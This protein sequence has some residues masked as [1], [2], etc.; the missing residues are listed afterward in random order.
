L[1]SLGRF[2]YSVT[3]GSYHQYTFS[4]GE[5]T[6]LTAP[7]PSLTF[8]E[9]TNMRGKGESE[10]SGHDRWVLIDGHSLAYRAFYALP[11]DLATTSGQLTNAVY[12]FTSMLIKVMEEFKPHAVIVAFDKGKPEFRT[13]R[14][15]EYKAHRKPMPDELRDQMD[16]IH[17]VLDSLGIP[18]L[19]E[20]GFEADDV[21]A[22]L[23]DIL[24]QDAEIYIVTSDRD[25]MQLVD[26]RVK[27]IANRKGISDIAVF[28]ARG[29]K[30][31]FGV[32]PGQIVDYLAL[33]G[34]TSDNI[35]GV[36]GIGEKTAAAL[37]GEYGSL[38]DVY[39]HIREIKAGRARKALEDNRDSALMSRELATM[40]HDVPIEVKG[41][42]NWDLKPWDEQAVRR[43]FDSME[44]RKL[45][46]R[47]ASLKMQLFQASQDV[48]E[49]AVDRHAD[50]RV[51]VMDKAGLEQVLRCCKETGEMSLFARIQGEGYTRGHMDSINVACGG[52]V[53]RFSLDKKKGVDLLGVFLEHIS[54]TPGL[55]LNCYCGKDIMVQCYKL[56]SFYTRFDFDVELASYL[57][58]PSGS[59][60]DIESS[61]LHYLGLSLAAVP[62][63]QLDLLQDEE[64]IADHDI[65]CTM[66]LEELVEPLQS[67]MNA[68]ELR[69]LF[70][71]VEMPLQEVLAE[72]EAG[73]IRLD[74]GILAAMQV[75]LEKELSA[76]EEQA[77]ELA[78][79]R[80]NLN[81]PQQLSRI[82]FEV[83]EL[84][85]LR[86]TKTGFATDI[87]VLTAL[88]E[89]HPIAGIL[90]RYRELSKLLNTYVCALPKL[91]DPSTGRLHACF[92][93]AVTATG[94]LSSSNP[95]LQ[96]IPVRTALGKT[97]RK[98]FI[99]T[100]QDGF[101]LSA[102]YSQIELRVMAHL[103]GDEGLRLAFEED[104]DIHAS[105]ASEVFGVPFGEV[106]AEQRRKAKAINFGIIYG[107]SPFGL[108]GQLGIEQEEADRYI[109]EYFREFPGVR[110]FLDRQVEEATR[111]GYVTTLLGRRREIP[112]LAEGNLRLRRLGERLAFNTPIQGSAADIIKVAMLRI[113]E[114]LKEGG[115]GSRMILQ[116]HDELVFD[117][118]TNE[119]EAL[120]DLVRQEMESACE[121]DVPLKVDMGLGPSWYEVK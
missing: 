76:L 65:R 121:L 118:A 82:L 58:N 42:S 79:E 36:P 1:N 91:I 105:T 33:K 57:V 74:A 22:T 113:H 112:E 49:E 43:V 114:R 97:I 73:G 21:L 28:D 4:L 56:Y 83:L 31:K 63:G 54:S 62:S 37:I 17:G 24:P 8:I 51:D 68:R 90:V 69:P 89:V 71:D 98:A 50:S 85:P 12:G 39:E 87:N 92:N 72:M 15:A 67:D 80:F 107:I 34:D 30:D 64:A 26:E 61:A 119:E 109:S 18:F 48:K 75:E 100:S 11:P 41:A 44:F 32:D 116:V 99:P 40:R 45:Y 55:R 9:E 115:Y 96:N 29:V 16:L 95:N 93:Q 84:P 5:G 59:K 2:S 20:E 3:G 46:E 13:E 47:L 78:G 102:D 66:A 38:D 35:P 111:T 103:S 86:R 23:T 108:S 101:I 6:G 25:A 14:F 53:F 60:H 110:D 117:V 106:T 70:E 88:S 7:S 94:R 52:R 104:R 27:V 77:C 10:L 120:R 81:S 19:E